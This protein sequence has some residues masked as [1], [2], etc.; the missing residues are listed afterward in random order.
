[1]GWLTRHD[2]I[3][4]PVAYLAD[5]HNYHDEYRRCRVLAAARVANTVYMALECTDKTSGTSFVLAVVILIFNTRKRGFG[6]KDMD[7][8]MGPC[9]CACPDHIM[10]LLSPVA[11]IP[12]PSYA[13]DWRARVAAHKQAGAEL[14]RKRKSLHP[15]S[16]VT[17]PHLVSFRDGTTA[18][19]FRVRCLRGRTPIFEPLDR[20]GFA[21][22]LRAATLAAADIVPPDATSVPAQA[23]E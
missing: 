20:P 10:R 19:A 4:D 6:Y 14:R 5:R 7:E 3:D 21:C 17:L 16:V 1:M 8:T 12:N 18:T 15:G 22:R 11:D 9:E 2:P 23:G 13:A